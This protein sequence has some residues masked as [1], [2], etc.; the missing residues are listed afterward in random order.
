MSG[1]LKVK[2]SW[3]VFFKSK[4]VLAFNQNLILTNLRYSTKDYFIFERSLLNYFY[5][6][7]LC[8]KSLKSWLVIFGTFL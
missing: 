3:V 6:N 4:L 1:I 5:I 8:K 2:E 7:F